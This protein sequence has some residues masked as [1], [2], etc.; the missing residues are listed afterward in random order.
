MNKLKL[1]VPVGTMDF[2]PEEYA[3]RRQILDAV[4][5]EF[6]LHGYDPVDT[7]A[8][9]Y[10]DVF[11][12]DS[13]PY[14]QENIIKF[15]DS[16]GR[17]LALRPDMTGPIARMVSTRVNAKN[18]LLR[19]SY[20]GSV[21][22]YKN[23]M[24]RA[25]YTQAGIELLGKS[26]SQGDAEVISIAIGC[27]NKIGL[28]DFTIDIGQV[29]FFKGLAIE[30]GLDNKQIERIRLLIDS[31]NSVELEFELSKMKIDKR[32]KQSFLKLINLF[33]N[34]DV[35]DEAE[36]I[37][38]NAYCLNALNNIKSVYA[39]L[40]DYGFEKNISID[41]G[42]LNNF[43][44][45]SGILFRGLING[46]GHPVLAGGRYDNLLKE[47]GGDAP[48]TGFAVCIED[49]MTALNNNTHLSNDTDKINV[50]KCNCTNRKKAYTYAE[51]LRNTGKRVILDAE[52]GNYDA[53]FFKIIEFS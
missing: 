23:G 28:K 22:G 18:N 44:Y 37:T 17:I 39:I 2:L 13:V 52:N 7:P 38:Y 6:L 53:N 50:I 25:Q 42:L 31:K 33:G 1:K 16:N 34:F 47:F 41:L 26:G 36:S 3:Q 12:H 10:Y 48:A 35:L 24:Q 14:T 43:N 32:L 21:F 29:E 30:A 51:N 46:V 4:E 11:T 19:F 40:C 8:F 27:L 45:Y 49:L 5:S 20:A 9:E 15:F